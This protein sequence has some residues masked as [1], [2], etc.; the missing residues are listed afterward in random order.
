VD[1]N[2]ANAYCTWAGRRLPTEAEWEKATRST[3]GRAYPWGNDV[4]NKILLNY[5]SNVGDTTAVA[6]YQNGA[7]LYGAY[8][9]AGNVMEWVNDVYSETYY[10]G[11]PSSNP[12]GPDATSA[13]AV[14]VLRGGSWYDLDVRSGKRYM[15]TP[16]FPTDHYGFRCALGISP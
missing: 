12:A 3:D 2:Q 13:G 7:S 16:V 15:D 1:W 6:H 4:P 9:M 10:Q 8:D 14:R 5:N 11:S